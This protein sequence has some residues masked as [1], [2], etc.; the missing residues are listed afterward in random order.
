MKSCK[1]EHKIE[2]DVEVS[3]ARIELIKLYDE[4]TEQLVGVDALWSTL[5]CLKLLLFIMLDFSLLSLD[6]RFETSKYKQPWTCFS[7]RVKYRPLV[8]CS[9]C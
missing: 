1:L 9:V 8:V 7:E 4:I 6:L 3:L 2:F 5:A